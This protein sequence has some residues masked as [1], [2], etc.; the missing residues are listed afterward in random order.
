MALLMHAGNNSSLAPPHPN[1][2]DPSSHFG[3]TPVP[4][5]SEQESVNNC[6]E[7]F[8]FDEN[9]TNICRPICGE[10]NP[11]PLGV[12]ILY[13]ISVVIGSIAAVTVIILAL[14]VQREKL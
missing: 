11:V 4:S 10:L 1:T 3:T 7:E 14:A 12:Q 9:V 5:L 2:M 6:S 13:K 8:F